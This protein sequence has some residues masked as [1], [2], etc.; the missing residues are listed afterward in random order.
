MNTK[1]TLD[2][3]IRIASEYRQQ[4]YAPYS[5]FPVGA[6]VLAESGDIFGGCNIENGVL[7]LT[8]CAE[9][10]AIA[11][12]VAAG[13]RSF[14]QIVIVAH[15]LSPPC[16]ACRQVISEFASSNLIVTAVDADNPKVQQSWSM[17]ELLP[18]DFRFEKR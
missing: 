18:D 11:S 6:A 2:E 14:L 15:P 12:T 1:V 16:G 7:G 5:K 17:E 8:N 13:Q 9:R 3:L 10:V 4:A